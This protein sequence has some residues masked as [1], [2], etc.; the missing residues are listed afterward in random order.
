MQQSF[1]VEIAEDKFIIGEI[2]LK[3]GSEKLLD[4]NPVVIVLPGGPGGIKELYIGNN[5]FLQKHAHIV[6]FDPRGCGE[7]SMFDDSSAY[8]MTTYIDDVEAIRQHLK[9]ENLSLL[10]TSY[11]SMCA[12]A[13]ACKYSASVNIDRLIIVNGAYSY[14][15]LESAKKNLIDFAKT[16]LF[17]DRIQQEQLKV[18][19]TLWAGNFKT[20]DELQNYVTVM[21]PVYSIKTEPGAK[22]QISKYRFNIEP[23]N[24]AFST[25]F[26]HF[27]LS[28][29]LKTVKAKKAILIVGEHDWINP[30]QFAKYTASQIHGCNLHIIKNAGHSVAADQ[31][32]E[33]QK[34]ILSL[35]D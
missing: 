10:G 21:G 6:F 12:Q 7:S 27:D 19:E 29:Q 18:C 28:D 13:Y 26:W 8:T 3:E 4:G 16:D 1:N 17:K 14:H 2:Y 22:A 33:Y 30:P 9:I 11:G 15:F 5:L 25:E 32:E 35:F 31:P 23:L 20:S 24:E 34:L